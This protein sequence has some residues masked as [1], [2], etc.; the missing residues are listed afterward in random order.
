[1]DKRKTL[2]YGALVVIAF[3]YGGD[4]AFRKLYE[5]PMANGQARLLALQAE[6]NKGAQQLE[7]LSRSVDALDELQQRALPRNLELARSA[8]QGWLVQIVQDAKLQQPRVDSGDPVARTS[9]WIRT[10]PASDWS[11]CCTTRPARSSSPTVLCR[12][13]CRRTQSVFTREAPWASWTTTAPG[14]CSSRVSGAG[15]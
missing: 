6:L 13:R 11:S 1:M 7:Y 10:I 8:Y 4:A 15:A 3:F 5:E 2:L 12:R 9:R 14:V